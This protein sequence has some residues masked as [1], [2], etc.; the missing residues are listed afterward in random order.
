[1]S[2]SGWCLKMC[3]QFGL[4]LGDLAVELDD[5]ADRDTGRRA[6]RGGDRVVSQFG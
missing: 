2:G 6:E 1:M 4:E 3:R 5:D